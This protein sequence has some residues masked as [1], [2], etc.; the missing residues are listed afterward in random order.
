[1]KGRIGM[2]IKALSASHHMKLSKG[3]SRWNLIALLFWKLKITKVA[4]VNN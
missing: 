3:K 4:V 2:Q 1:M